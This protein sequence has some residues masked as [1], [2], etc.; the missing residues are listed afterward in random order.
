M[1]KPGAKRAERRRS[2][3][4]APVPK[5]DTVAPALPSAPPDLPAELVPLWE[6]VVSELD[7]RGSMPAALREVDVLLLGLLFEAIQTHRL[8]SLDVRERGLEVAG[9]YGPMSN[10]SLK[11]QRDAA[12]TILRLVAELGLSPAARTRL[13]LQSLIGVSLLSALR[14]EVEKAVDTRAL[15]RRRDPELPAPSG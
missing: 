8:A 14:H 7:S 9:R 3:A 11:V 12:A 5:V 15:G 10:P 4:P 6:L 13:G 2:R 1:P